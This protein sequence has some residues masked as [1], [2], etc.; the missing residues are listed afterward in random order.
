MEIVCLGFKPRVGGCRW[1]AVTGADGELLGRIFEEELLGEFAYVASV[2]RPIGDLSGPRPR[3]TTTLEAALDFIARERG[4]AAM[5]SP[6][7][8]DQ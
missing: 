8:A 3:H 7:L 5:P 6:S 2:A 4:R 1:I